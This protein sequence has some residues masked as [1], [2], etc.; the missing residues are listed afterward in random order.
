MHKTNAQ[1]AVPAKRQEGE[2]GHL[3]PFYDL[4]MTGITLGRE[5]KL[6]QETIKLSQIKPGDKV[7]EIGCGTGTLSLAAKAQVGPTGKV[8]GIDLAPEMVAKACAKAARKGA[9][10][11]FQE[12]SI[13]NIPFPDNCF[14]AVMCSF[15]IYHM[16]EDVR[17]KGLTEINR[18]LKPDGHLFVIDTEPLDK[19]APVLKEYPFTEIELAKKKFVY[20]WL[21]FLR[22]KVDK[23]RK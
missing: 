16:P 4:M 1:A 10:V 2:R 18:V 6:R 8:V 23:P 14:D 21:W 19:L 9:D 20:L 7:L 22:A 17:R 13:T 15:M 3:A 5:K 12:A 11:S